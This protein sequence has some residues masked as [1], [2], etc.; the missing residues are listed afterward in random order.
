MVVFGTLKTGE[1]SGN[2][3]FTGDLDQCREYT[4]GLDHSEY[5]ELSICQDDGTITE[6]IVIPNTG[7]KRV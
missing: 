7:K 4:D 2:I 5:Y 1:E 6:K 3:L